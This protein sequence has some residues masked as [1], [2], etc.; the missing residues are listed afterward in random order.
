MLLCFGINRF[1]LCAL[2]TWQFAIFFASQMLLPAQFGG[3]LLGTFT[4]GA[5]S[6]AFGRRPI[7]IFALTFGTSSILASA[8]ATTWQFLLATR[9]M[10]LRAFINWV[11]WHS[12]PWILGISLGDCA[13]AISPRALPQGIARLALTVLCLLF[14]HWQSAS[15]VCAIVERLLFRLLHSVLH[16]LLRVCV[17]STGKAFHASNVFAHPW[18][19]R[20]TNAMRAFWHLVT[21]DGRHICLGKKLRIL[22]CEE[23]TDGLRLRM[24]KVLDNHNHLS[25]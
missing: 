5:L 4:S 21:E 23:K 25:C 12:L 3:V 20:W 1:H 18:R 15:I 10:A 2:L 16:L 6:D 8:F 14:P 17:K 22:K 11:C 19:I 9:F 24:L 13:I 7:A